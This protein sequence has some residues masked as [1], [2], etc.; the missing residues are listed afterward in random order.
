M[1]RKAVQRACQNCKNAH[2]CCEEQRPCSRC[3]KLGIES[4][5]FDALPKKRGR[6]KKIIIPLPPE[7]PPPDPKRPRR[8]ERLQKL[9]MRHADKSDMNAFNEMDILDKVVKSESCE[10]DTQLIVKEEE[11]KPVK[12]HKNFMLRLSTKIEFSEEKSI[13]ENKGSTNLKLQND[14]HVQTE[15]LIEVMRLQQIVQ[16][17]AKEVCILKIN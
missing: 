4:T 17:Q 3:I 8:S 7:D 11:S 13:T 15:L 10:K 9:Q 1:K 5:C 2:T 12:K 14:P 6:K 16:D